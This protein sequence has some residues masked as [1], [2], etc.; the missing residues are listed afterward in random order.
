VTY[1]VTDNDGNTAS[2]TVSVNIVTPDWSVSL[3]GPNELDVVDGATTGSY[4][5]TISTTGSGS[6]SYNWY[7]TG[8][9]GLSSGG[10]SAS[11]QAT[12]AEAPNTVYVTVTVSMY[13][14]TR[15]R[16]MRTDVIDSG[17]GGGNGDNNG[18]GND[19]SVS[20][21]MDSSDDSIQSDE[22]ASYSASASTNN[23]NA[24]SWSWTHSGDGSLS[25][26]GNSAT[27]T[28]AE[29][30]E[31]GSV[32]VT[33]TAQADDSSGTQDS[34][35]ASTD[36]VAP[37]ECSLNVEASGPST[38][39][40]GD[41]LSYS[42]NVDPSNCNA[43]SYSWSVVSGDGSVSAS[44]TSATYS[45]AESDRGNTVE[46]EVT[47]TADDGSTTAEDMVTTS[48]E[49]NEGE[50]G[51]E[52][53][54]DDNGNGNGLGWGRPGG[55]IDGPLTILYNDESE[56]YSGFYEVRGIPANGYRFETFEID[57]FETS[58]GDHGSGLFT[59]DDSVNTQA[60][61]VTLTAVISNE[62]FAQERDSVEE[63]TYRVSK[64]IVLC[65]LPD[66]DDPQIGDPESPS[67]CQIQTPE[68]TITGAPSVVDIGDRGDQYINLEADVQNVQ[69]GQDV[70]VEWS[71]YRVEYSTERSVTWA[72]PSR[73]VG[74]SASDRVD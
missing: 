50:D 31:G 39:Q 28:P 37:G 10:P 71:G 42:T 43:D 11:Y 3:S 26:S 60:E 62:E 9:S 41:S 5:A 59:F 19:C 22:T 24:D 61:T 68:V 33:A 63:D 49:S 13:G 44:E 29:S 7:V 12:P 20:V 74:R 51:S 48:I 25:S 36:V 17:D 1:T 2:D 45:V 34:A 32:T 23:C 67:G 14:E 72:E 18:G 15:S 52:N 73:T 35:S 16:T 54:S 70:T 21:T 4:T 53:N 65:P 46:V 57:G 6:P 69:Y 38:G 40:T 30:D 8:G 27:Y 64:E 56:T 58:Q 55:Y 66:G 47:V